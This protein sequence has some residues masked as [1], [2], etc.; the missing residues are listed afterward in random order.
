MKRGPHGSPSPSTREYVGK[1][2]PKTIGNVSVSWGRGEIT[3]QSRSK[4]PSLERV[5]AYVTSRKLSVPSPTV[6]SDDG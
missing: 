3:R 4:R 5:M 6:A 1:R 2:K